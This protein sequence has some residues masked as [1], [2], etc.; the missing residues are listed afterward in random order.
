M[1]DRALN[2]PAL[3]S[4]GFEIPLFFIDQS[5]SGRLLFNCGELCERE[6]K[7]FGY[8]PKQLFLDYLKVAF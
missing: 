8:Q 1:F 6:V 7:I 3:F 5:I 4:Q 2:K